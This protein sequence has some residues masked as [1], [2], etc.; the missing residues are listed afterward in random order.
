M[1][2]DG[3]ARLQEWSDKHMRDHLNRLEAKMDRLTEAVTALV[4]VEE[5]QMTHGQRI[6]ALESRASTTETNI[7]NVRT[8]LSKWINRGVGGWALVIVLWTIYLAVAAKD[9]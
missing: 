2:R 1:E 4:R 6:G 8:E 9:W 5:R 3:A 7:T